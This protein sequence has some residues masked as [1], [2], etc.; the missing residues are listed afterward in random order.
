MIEDRHRYLVVDDDLAFAKA[1]AG[2]LR[3]RGD[4]AFIANDL[5]SAL[6][7][8]TAHH[9]SRAVVDLRLGGENG[10]EVV[11]ALAERFPRLAVVVLTGYGSIPTAVEAMRLG[12]VNY[13]TKPASAEAIQAAFEPSGTPA[14]PPT[15]PPTLEELE[16]DH[17]Q[18]VLAE[19]GHNVSE[20]ARRLGMHRRTLQRK[21]AR[22]RSGENPR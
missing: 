19:T 14:P 2:A 3:R 13:L 6:A 17:I 9:P 5:R 16:W 4:V 8:A 21:L 12:A 18:R 20:T 10:L 22:K 11:R 1:L 15:T 7:E